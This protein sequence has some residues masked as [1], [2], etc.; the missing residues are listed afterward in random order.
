MKLAECCS[1]L[2]KRDEG[3]AMIDAFLQRTIE[4]LRRNLRLRVLDQSSVARVTLDDVVAA[5]ARVQRTARFAV[6]PCAPPA[7]LLP[8]ADKHHGEF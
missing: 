4:R 1:N 2:G 3:L 6:R 5:R 7:G 8:L